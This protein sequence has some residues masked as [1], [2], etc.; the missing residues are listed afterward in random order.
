MDYRSTIDSRYKNNI[1]INSPSDPNNSSPIE[2]IYQSGQIN[3]YISIIMPIYNQESIIEKNIL[4]I[5][6]CTTELSY[7]LILILD[8]C[9]DA[10]ESVIMKMIRDYPLPT[11]LVRILVLKSLT[12]LF[13][14][15]ADNLGFICS[16]G[17]FIL[18][19]QAD[20]EMTEVGY[21]MKL[22]KPFSI[23]SEILGISGRCCHGL[24]TNEGI[25][26]LGELVENA[27]PEYIDRNAFY[28]GETC[29]RGPLMLDNEKLRTLGYLDE[30]N[31]FLDNSDHDLFAR[32]YS[33]KGWVCGYCP[34]DYSSPLVN[35]STRKPRDL[36]N[37]VFFKNKMETCKGGFL[38]KYLESNPPSRNI[39]KIMLNQD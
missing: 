10:T 31:Y 1:F 28:I 9:S 3:P 15:A 5:F 33:E 27:L 32:A 37:E 8:S 39:Q 4:S 36:V 23:Y 30:K 26:K 6:K 17:K 11:L 13:E 35:G 34:I 20:M 22:L 24:T 2:I 12:P 14:T 25:G 21:N 18:E 38:V 7:E 19:I 16:T 29:N